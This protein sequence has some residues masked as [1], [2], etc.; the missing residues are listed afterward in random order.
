[1]TALEPSGTRRVVQ[2]CENGAAP[3][4]LAMVCLLFHDKHLSPV[5]TPHQPDG[6]T[7]QA[8]VAD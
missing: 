5:D 6:E 1:M 2:H 3:K 7:L 4:R 8:L